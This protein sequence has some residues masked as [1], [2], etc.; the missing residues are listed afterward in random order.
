MNRQEFETKRRDIAAGGG[1]PAPERVAR[2]TEFYER[3]QAAAAAAEKERRERSEARLK[4]DLKRAYMRSPEA[5]EE[6]FEREY[7][8]LR[9]EYLRGE[10]LRR[11]EAERGAQAALYRGAF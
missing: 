7:P 11:A 4:A 6:D 3:Q 1:P 9:G 5:R 2:L 8:A 10:A